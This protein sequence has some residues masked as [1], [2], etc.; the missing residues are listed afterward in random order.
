M[1]KRKTGKIF[2]EHYKQQAIANNISIQTVYSRLERGWDLEKAVNT[3]PVR[4]TYI[5]EAKRE[6][7]WI[8]P[9]DRPRLKKTMGVNLYQDLEPLFN[10]ALEESGLSRSDFV[11][12]AVEQYLLKLWTPKKNLS[13]IK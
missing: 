13:K 5:H 3:P 4:K 6:D 7:G 9:S 1:V 10:E 12:N 2:P 11:A 8:V